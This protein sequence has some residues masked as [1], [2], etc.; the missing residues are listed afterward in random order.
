MDALHLFLKNNGE[1]LQRTDRETS[2]FSDVSWNFNVMH[3]A[4]M[5]LQPQ[6][7][8]VRTAPQRQCED[9]AAAPGWSEGPEARCSVRGG[10]GRNPVRLTRRCQV[11]TR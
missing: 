1:A 8:A 11:N 4:R 5:V 7:L 10:S 9:G 6:R 2:L 3:I